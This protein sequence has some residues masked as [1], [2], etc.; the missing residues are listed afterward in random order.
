MSGIAAVL[1]FD[2]SPVAR[3]ELERVANVLKPY[4]AD[5]QAILTRENAGFVFCLDS[6]TPEDFF[7]R[8]PVIL[9]NRIILLF[10]GR[11]DNRLE[12]SQSLRIPANDLLSMSDSMLALR[13]FDRWSERGFE[14]ILGD[15]AIII[16]DLQSRRLICARDQMGLRVLH[17]YCSR[18]QF[19]AAT[20]P[21][22][23]FAL[24]WV[25]RI[26]N[27]DKVGDTLVQRGLNGETTYYKQI[28]R[29]LPGSFVSVQGRSVSKHQFWDPVNIPDVRFKNDPD[30]VE[31]FKEYLYT[32][33]SARLRSRRVPCST[34]T[35]GLDSS[36]IS[37][38]AADILAGKG[39]KLN[40]FT[41]VPEHGFSREELRGRY[42]DETPYVRLIAETNPNIVPHFITPT[43]GPI[44]Q[45][46]AEQ[47][48]V[49]GAPSGGILNGLWV[50]DILAAARSAG[51][52]VMLGGEMGN[53]TMSYG[54]SG[55]YA[56]LLR[57]G[58]WWRLLGEIRASGHRRT[59]VIR[60]LTIAPFVPARLY[61]RYKQW[62]RGVHPPWQD[63]SA[64]HP[65]F[66]ARSGVVDRASR[67]YLPFDAP[68]PRDDKL[69]RIH[70]FHCFSETADWFAKVRAAFRVDIR[71]PAFDRRLV[72]YCLAI[73]TDQYLNRGCDRWLIR[74]A[75][76]GRLPDAVLQNK[77]RG[78][79]AADWFP[80]L[81]RERSH[82]SEEVKRLANNRTVS[83]IIDLQKLTTILEE[84][85]DGQPPEY[86]LQQY[87][88]FWA[89]PQALGAA[90]FIEG[91]T[92]A[93]Y[94]R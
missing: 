42:F 62:R 16:M 50:M 65:E 25:P 68:P 93:N 28:Y 84:W 69:G 83:S 2:G 45:K 58:R 94:G 27:E 67:E 21:E 51:H 54:G 34:L 82:I 5:R 70:D 17:Y 14:R 9:A 1:N 3:S 53:F 89:L 38:I 8:Q 71:T 24:S 52:N 61:R 33:V 75:M 57:T 12:L 19:A 30:Y 79:Q 6:A 4:G 63:F 90:Y 64:I 48:R 41:A 73:P 10:D 15:F 11:I 85:P 76:N 74:R 39:S 47:I 32:A 35:G 13:L 80:R 78:A 86:S 37:V 59:R 81:T 56:A 88:L 72:E 55:L 40:T 44:L 7:E 23:L 31:A 60:S 22:A 92:G 20:V 29:V 77:K 18:D 26:L 36:S 49:G 66:A 87:P 43:Q 91:V 46:I